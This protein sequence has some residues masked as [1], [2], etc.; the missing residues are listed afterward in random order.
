MKNNPEVVIEV[1]SS[2]RILVVANI[3]N[4]LL[5]DRRAQSTRE[6]LIIN[7]IPSNKVKSKAFGESKL[8]VSQ[9]EIDA[10]TAEEQ[11]EMHELNRRTEFIIV[12]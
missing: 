3:I 9:E 6:Y 2:I 11:E 8:K 10:A 4:L 7:G 12:E 1:R 5:S